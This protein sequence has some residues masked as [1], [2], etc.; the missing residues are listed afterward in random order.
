[1]TQ[2]THKAQKWGKQGSSTA[3]QTHLA[4]KLSTTDNKTIKERE[5]KAEYNSKRRRR[6]V[7]YP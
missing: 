2:V 6:L 5:T 7:M 1:M 4:K 3:R